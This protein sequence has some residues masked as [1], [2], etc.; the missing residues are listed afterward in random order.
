MSNIKLIITHTRGDLDP[1][2]LFFM[3]SDYEWTLPEGNS[4]EEVLSKFWGLTSE[5]INN[6]SFVERCRLLGDNNL[7]LEVDEDDYKTLLAAPFLLDAPILSVGSFELMDL[8]NLLEDV[9]ME[10][11]RLNKVD[12]D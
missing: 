11:D 12:N 1:K 4:V 8:G 3:D 2:V 7:H 9:Q 6:G 10:M 5:D